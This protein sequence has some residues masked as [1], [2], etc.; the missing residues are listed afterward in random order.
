MSFNWP[1]V[2][3]TG[4]EVEAFVDAYK[5]LAQTIYDDWDDDPYHI[6]SFPVDGSENGGE[7]ISRLK[8]PFRKRETIKILLEYGLIYASFIVKQRAGNSGPGTDFELGN[9]P[10]TP[11]LTIDERLNLFKDLGCVFTKEAME[12]AYRKNNGG[13]SPPV[14]LNDLDIFPDGGIPNSDVDPDDTPLAENDPPEDCPDKNT[15]ENFYL[16]LGNI[17]PFSACY[18]DIKAKLLDRYLSCDDSVF[19][20][21]DMGGK[22]DSLKNGL[23]EFMD[24]YQDGQKQ[25]NLRGQC[26]THKTNITNN[27]TPEQK[28]R[29]GAGPTDIIWQA[30]FYGSAGQRLCLHTM[31]GNAIVITNSSGTVLRVLDDFDFVYGNEADRP[32]A[33]YSG[34]PNPGKKPG[35]Y[36]DPAGYQ[37]DRDDNPVPVGHPNAV[38]STVYPPIDNLDNLPNNKSPWSPSEVGRN[39]VGSNYIGKNGKGQPVPIN[40]SFE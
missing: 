7:P 21:S 23:Q 34:Q 31:F 13:K 8:A 3:F 30:S 36:F 6:Y 25:C 24:N 10:L 35:L 11:A 9:S 14:D 22:K 38:G 37:L 18:R 32:D 5:E 15:R 1:D 20:A 29:M 40:I 27:F 26:V 12:C 2:P 39:I 33:S 4:A 19:T 28:S 17:P 16:G